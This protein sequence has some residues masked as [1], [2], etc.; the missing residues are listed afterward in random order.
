MVTIQRSGFILDNE[1][2]LLSDSYD[3]EKK[4]LGR[5]TYGSVSRAMNKSTKLIRAIKT[6]S[7][8]HLKN[9]VR[10]RQEIAIMK[11]LDHP[12]IVKLFETFED[13]KNI[14]LVLELCTGGE[15]F[16]RI[17]DQGYFT[18]RG[19]ASLM[20]QAISAVYYC[21][22]NNI[23]HRD[24]KPE[25][26]LFLN[27]TKNSPLKII[28]FGLAAKFGDN[29]HL[30]TKA[31][32]PYYVSPQV[33][34]GDYNESCDLWSCGVIMYILLCGYPPFHGDTDAQ[35]LARVRSGK[36]NF[37]DEDWKT[38]SSDAKDLIRKLLTFDQ[39]LRWTAEQALNHKWIKNLAKTADDDVDE[40][41][42]VV[43]RLRNFRAQN[44]MKKVALTVIAQQLG[45][46]DIERLKK[47]FQALDENGDGTLTMQEIKEG[48]KSL[49][50]SLPADL[51][52]IMMDVD[53]DGSG[54][55]D[56]TEFIAATID[57]KTYIQEDVCWAAF[58]LFDLDGNGKITQEELQK[59][60][61]NDDVKTALGQD[62]VSKMIS[63][64]DLDGDGEIDFDE[65]MT[66]MHSSN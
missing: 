8:S 40:H 28:D 7:K 36:Y 20:K 5:G 34:Q 27:K 56:Y 57:K 37:P 10:F 44:K 23:V 17:I 1:G 18:E 13:A 46:A 41:R 30:K 3:V 9:V 63:E 51:E 48:M 53:S 47:T 4:T 6:I 32:T 38:V 19:A 66:M 29:V 24:L 12:N 31:G 42:N 49:D 11:M 61:S 22:K 54:A 26:F 15:L 14:Y 52:E 2:K 25:N 43:S 62:T 45:D 21:H 59:V 16:D 65:F 55:I 50:V 33:L 60:L 39:A 35:I 64:V 58:R